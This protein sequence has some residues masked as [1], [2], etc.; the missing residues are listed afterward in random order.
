MSKYN[1]EETIVKITSV[2]STLF[3]SKG[4]DNTSIQDIINGVGMSKGAIYHHFKSKEDILHAILHAH[5]E[6]VVRRIH[7]YLKENQSLTAKDKLRGILRKNWGY[8]ESHQLEDM[9]LSQNQN[10]PF[11]LGSLQVSLK[12]SAPLIADIIQEGRSDGSLSVQYPEECSEVFFLLINFWCDPV[13]IEGSIDDLERR[14]K[15]LQYLMEMM[16]ADIV[17]DGLIDHMV[18]IY[19]HAG[20]QREGKI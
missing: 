13:L 19:S 4:Y 11:I 16:G 14:L 6:E 9:M 17:E 15:F 3:I 20:R 7:A 8:I 12:S 2:A 1:A 18:H 10:A 5:G